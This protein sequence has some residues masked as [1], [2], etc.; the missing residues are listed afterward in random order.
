MSTITTTTITNFPP[1]GMHPVVPVYVHPL[2]RLPGG[3][4]YQGEEK[5]GMEHERPTARGA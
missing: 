2:H 5:T 3:I 1:G 4:N